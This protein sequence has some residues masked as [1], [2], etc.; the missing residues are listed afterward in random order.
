MA[1]TAP[2]PENAAINVT[3]T[4]EPEDIFAGIKEPMSQPPGAA[5]AALPP[6]APARSGIKTLLTIIIPLA[7]LGLGVGGWFAYQKFFA[8]KPVINL[9]KSTDQQTVLPVTP[10]PNEAPGTPNP[11]PKP[12]EDQLAAAQ[13]TISMMQGQANAAAAT[14]ESLATSTEPPPA[15]P[16]IGPNGEIVTTTGTEVTEPQLP[17]TNPAIPLPEQAY[18]QALAVGTDSDADGLT[19]AEELALGTDIMN[20]D[21][22]GDGFEDGAEVN[23]GYDPLA[24]NKKIEDSVGIK[25]ETVGEIVI[26]VPKSWERTAGM[27]GTINVKTGSP[28]TFGLSLQTFAAGGSLLDWV[29]AQ[30]PGTPATDYTTGKNTNGFDVVY[31]KDGMTAWLLQGNTVTV[32]RYATN[33]APTKDFGTLFKLMVNQARAAK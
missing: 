23:S 21:T 27:G 32:F 10:S 19:N 26:L 5:S 18:N 2:S 31:S 7:V 20:K 22:D 13:A 4:K 15:I 33:G 6:T 30:N 24:K 14:T 8:P 1:A 3:G 9:P 11:F 17:A 16:E 28:S 29:M 12:N 25:S